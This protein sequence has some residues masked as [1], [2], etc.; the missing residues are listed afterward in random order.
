MKFKYI[1]IFDFVFQ[2]YKEPKRLGY[3]FCFIGFMKQEKKK[4][5]INYDEKYENG[6]MR[7]TIGIMH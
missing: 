1:T 2:L 3:Q 4:F 7:I 6:Y 5:F